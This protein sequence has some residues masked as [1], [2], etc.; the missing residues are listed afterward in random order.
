M[1]FLAGAENRN[2]YGNVH[3]GSMM[4]WMDEGAGACAAGWS[5]LPCVTVAVSGN[6]VEVRARLIHTGRT[7]MH[8]AVNVCSRDP[9]HGDY[10]DTTSCL[11][12]FVALDADARP[13]PVPKWE[14]TAPEDRAIQARAMHL[15]ELGQRIQEELRTFESAAAD[16]G[17]AAKG[18][19]M[20][21]I[22]QI[23]CFHPP[24]YREATRWRRARHEELLCRG[25]AT[26]PHPRGKKITMNPMG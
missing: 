22:G 20:T 13:T 19:Q 10:D 17:K 3:G 16:G 23:W 2:V 15:R 24:S 7:S 1:R 6:I 14:P 21:Q 12:V 26:P 25:S 5:G 8:S 11:M 4:K 18:T 9:R